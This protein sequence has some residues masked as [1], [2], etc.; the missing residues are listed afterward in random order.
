[1]TGTVPR[2]AALVVLLVVGAL[3]LQGLTSTSSGDQAEVI[4]VVDGDTVRVRTSEGEG[5]SVRILGISAP[6]LTRDGSQA[7]CYAEASRSNLQDLLPEESP[8]TLVRDPTQDN[9]DTYGRLLR[10]VE[11]EGEDVGRA[12]IRDGAATARD[13][14]TPPTRHQSYLAAQ[15]RARA[16]S[17]GLWSSC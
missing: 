15:A 6:E 11:F 2:V 1:M 8:V 16:R 14:A 12:Q 13:S 10:Y 4:R 5:L 3:G 17:I 7:Q 9:F